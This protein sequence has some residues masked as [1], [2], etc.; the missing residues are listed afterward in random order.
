[1][2]TAQKTVKSKNAENN[3]HGVYFT[4]MIVASQQHVN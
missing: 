2:I 1:L 4:A 3:D